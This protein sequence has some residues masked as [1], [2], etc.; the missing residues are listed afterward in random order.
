MEFVVEDDNVPEQGVQ[1]AELV[2]DDHVPE[3]GVEEPS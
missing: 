1:F 3:Q 2:V